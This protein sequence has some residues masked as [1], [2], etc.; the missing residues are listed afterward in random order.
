MISKL[1]SKYWQNT[2]KYRIKI[3]KS[4]KEAYDFD[5]KNGNKFWTDG[6]KE[7][8]NKVI[9]EVQ[10]SNVSPDKSIGNQE[11]G[12]H[13][14]FDIEPGENFWRKDRIAHCG[15]TTK[16]PSSV[17]YRSMVSQD[18][19]QIM[20]M[21]AELNDL[22]LRAADIENTSLT[23]PCRKKIWIRAGQ[24]FRFDEGKVFI[25]VRALY[26]LKSSGETFWAFLED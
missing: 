1:R 25:V 17:T 26:G 2:H 22:D 7:V 12:L 5:E 10:E 11:I 14:I 13:M 15:H 18:L 4:E 23:A 9:V 6:I 8:M 21:I 20:L 24:E 19:V 3:P 16:T